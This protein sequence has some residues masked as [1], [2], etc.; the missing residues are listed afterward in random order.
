MGY[1]DFGEDLGDAKYSLSI[2]GDYGTVVNDS[3]N[4]VSDSVVRDCRFL[5]L[6][7]ADWF[8]VMLVYRLRLYLLL[9]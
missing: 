6:E 4:N 1:V 2:T 5:N 8:S 7:N 3:S 9:S